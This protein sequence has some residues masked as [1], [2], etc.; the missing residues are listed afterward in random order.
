MPKIQFNFLQ[1]RTDDKELAPARRA[2]PTVVGVVVSER[3]QLNEA[4]SSHRTVS[5]H[6]PEAP[7]S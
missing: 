6:G 7:H 1:G 5:A 4:E 2:A 3:D